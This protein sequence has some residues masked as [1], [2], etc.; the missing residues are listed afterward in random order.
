MIRPKT[1]TGDWNYCPLLKTVKR[2]LNKLIGKL[3]KQWN[4]ELGNRE[5]HSFQTTNLNREILVG[6]INEVTSVQFYFQLNRTK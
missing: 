2:L 3:K 6:W 1:E 4:F 5:K